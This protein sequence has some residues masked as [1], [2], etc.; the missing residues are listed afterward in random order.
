ML[1]QADWLSFHDAQ[2]F[3]PPFISPR[4]ARKQKNQQ[5]ISLAEQLQQLCG[6]AGLPCRF[7]K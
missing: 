3:L 5:P 2:Q 7:F 6:I 4:A 1:R